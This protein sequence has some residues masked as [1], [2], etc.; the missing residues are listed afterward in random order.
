VVVPDASVVAKWLLAG[1]E[2]ADLALRLRD[3]Y[4]SGET[5]LAMPALVLYEIASV[6]TNRRGIP[7]SA[8]REFVKLVNSLEIPVIQPDPAAL[9]AAMEIARR[10]GVSLYDAVYV[11]LAQEIGGCWVTAD[12]RAIAACREAI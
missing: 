7:L 2:G 8:G 10:S 11:Q 1:E 5:L 12:A 6:F 3:S 4:L 9:G